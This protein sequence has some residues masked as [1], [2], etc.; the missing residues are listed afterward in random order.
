[1][2]KFDIGIV[3][4]W[5][6]CNYGSMLTYYALHQVLNNLG[7]S[8]LMIHEA[9]GYEKG[10][11]KLSNNDAPHIFAEKHYKFTEQV[12]FKELSQFNDVC[13]IFIV[14]S[15]QLWNPYIS[16]VN[17]DCFLDFT[18][19]EIKRI[20][21]G[22][23]FGNK[24]VI[25]ANLQFVKDN[26]NN[27]RRFDAISVREEYAV[28]VARE[29]FG[30]KAVCVV[31]PVFL[32]DIS[33]Y[34]MLA[35]QATCKVEGKYLLAFILDPTEE[36]KKVIIKIANTMGFKKIFI[37]TDPYQSAIIKAEQI[38][39]E[40]NMEMFK[41]D[42][43]SVE[44]FLN[45]YRNAAYVVTDSFHGT[46]FAYIFHKNFN[47]FYNM[48]RGADRFVNVVGL[49]G[50]EN[51]RIYEDEH[52][53]LDLS[54]IDYSKAEENVNRSRDKSIKWL[55]N[56]IETPK[57]LM[58]S[59]ILPD[60]VDSVLKQERCTGCGMCE[61]ICPVQAITMKENAEGFLA[62]V[63][64]NEK[65]THCGLCYNKCPSE[66]PIYK[67]EQPI[68]YAMMADNEI[69]K[70]SSS[71]GMF[72]VVAAHILNQGGY[73]CGAVFKDDF[74]VQH[75]I[76]D[77]ISQIDRL[78]GSK[79]IQSYVGDVFPKIKRLL[80]ADNLVLFTGMPCQVAGLYAYLGQNYPKLYTIDLL[81]H[82]ITS[83][84]VF[85]KYKKDI[86]GDRQLTDLYFKAKEPWGWHAGINA[87]FSDGTKYAQPC[88]KDPYYI[89]YLNNISKNK[90]CG[91]CKFNKLPRQG[92]M[93]IGDFWGVNKFDVALNDNK[94]TSVVLVNNDKGRGLFE[95]LKNDMQV[96]K[97]VPLQIA[98]NG[99]HCIEHPYSLNKN[100]NVFFRYLHKLPFDVLATGCHDNR[101]YEKMHMHLYRD[102]PVEDREFYFIAK[103]VA[104]NS[105]GR[106]IVTWIR[107]GKFEHILKQ[108]FGLS[109]AFGVS[110]RK[111]ALRDNYILDYSI[112]QGRAKEYYLVSL[113]RNYDEETYRQLNS[114]G[115]YETR[116]FIF[117]MKKPVVLEK[118]DLSKGNYYDAYGNSIEGFN[119]V[120]GKVVFRGFNNHIVL[121]KNISTAGNLNF[122]F[123]ANGYV[124]IGDET[125]FNAVNKF[126][127]K[128]YNGCS[129]ITIGK[130]C[131]FTDA[132]WRLF[133]DV[134]NTSVV[135][136]DLCTFEANLEI[137]PNG[138]KKVIIGKD[139][140]FSYD[141]YLLAGDGHAIFDVNTAGRINDTGKSLPYKNSL[142]IGEHVWVGKNAFIMNGTN[143]GNG[144]I[145]GACSVVK[146]SF[147]NNCSIA[148]N[149]AKQIRTDIAW[150]RNAYADRLEQCGG[151]EY[152]ALTSS[153]KAPI[154][155]LNVLVVGG[156]RFMG[157][158][159]VKELL[160][161]GNTVTI[162]T[163]GNQPDTFG[164]HV[165]RI[166]M[167]VTNSMSVKEALDGKFYD[168]VFDDLAYCSENVDN[169]LSNVKCG[170]YI[171]LSSIASYVNRVPNMKEE[172]FEPHA[173]PL[174]MCNMSVDYG[175]GKRQAEAM[176]YQKYSDIPAVSVRIPYVA[177]TERLYY[178]A[179]NVV[180]QIPMKI[181]DTSRGFTFI[182]DTE[183]GKF[184]IW[185]AAQPFMGAIN[186]ASEGMVTIQM[187]LDY[188][189][190]KTGKKAIID[191]VNGVPSPFNER[192]FSLNMD[193]AKRLGYCTSNIDDWFWKLMDE[194]IARALRE[195]K[196]G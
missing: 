164:L 72:S 158:C 129:T 18:A 52:T 132:L 42:Q 70:V 190:E 111:E 73:V 113:D 103:I 131:R 162:A 104:E 96:A 97:E 43:I 125:R 79:Y 192:T 112:L 174:E 149:P 196:Q 1:M 151:I 122:D 69:R 82:G 23:S 181:E 147:P 140:M 68:C 95:S 156:T 127:L 49:L 48:L 108:Y 54:E 63:V 135:I 37:L 34:T 184:L 4:W 84:K 167:D 161:K 13:S 2:A 182:R 60:T 65:C 165:K 126:E 152:A 31:D 17:S 189:E 83:Y 136:N 98:I 92:D 153:A 107:S 12:Y 145:V 19:D 85:D 175:K 128:G 26:Y 171:Q 179:K 55:K 137:H 160:A 38:F 30:V 89:A 59:I 121:G 25:K 10:R 159:L 11:A 29:S 180:M 186:L 193:K 133:G 117:R 130:R 41:L 27:I 123:A 102:I 118:Y 163:R 5:Y 45:V 138:G 28:N 51:R 81:C 115:Y 105:N 142:V 91:T 169:V 66:S 58:P 106:E 146:G 24:G 80:E 157:I 88:E 78:R 61:Q 188:I 139:C 6:G 191:T 44:N 8:V 168:V 32:P 35:D 47:V 110:M 177:K 166:K 33:E 86:F 141:I 148:G 21:Y 143:I 75:V 183:V 94:G 14:G 134:H 3:G 7:Y 120:I 150:S 56:A 64:D 124:E 22:T 46:C 187:I 144:S 90:T 93:T 119:A 74:S 40:S 99:N 15:D 116:D 154:S 178:Y 100:R 170:K 57:E 67:N 76:I 155:G 20:S 114:F 77:N 101:L 53:V 50:L 173:I 194:Y 9:L 195:E 71:G 185:I 36:K 39:N 16:R 87:C 176:A 172:M 109:V 62:P